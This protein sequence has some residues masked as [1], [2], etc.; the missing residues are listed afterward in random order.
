M[1]KATSTR[2]PHAQHNYRHPAEPPPPN[3][4]ATSKQNMAYKD[5]P[6]ELDIQNNHD[7]LQRRRAFRNFVTEYVNKVNVLDKEVP[8]QRKAQELEE[9]KEKSM[10]Q[11]HAE[12]KKRMDDMQRKERMQCLQSAGDTDASRGGQRDN[13]KASSASKRP[14]RNELDA[15]LELKDQIDLEMMQLKKQID[16]MQYKKE[17]ILK[18]PT[19]IQNLKDD[20]EQ[21][22]FTNI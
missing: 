3:K 1:N 14:P 9:Q 20:I 21:V 2:P 4:Q 8:Q 11:R 17:Q 12:L 10:Q 15:D 18:K 16:K 22:V 13:D 6:F 19:K 7:I 5:R